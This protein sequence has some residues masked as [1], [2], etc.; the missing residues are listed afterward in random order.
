MI[1]IGNIVLW[2]RLTEHSFFAFDITSPADM[3]ALLY[4][5]DAPGCPLETYSKALNI[6]KGSELQ[7]KVKAISKDVEKF[8]QYASKPKE[9]GSSD[10]SDGESQK[11]SDIIG[12]IIFLGQPAPAIL[13]M[14]IDYL[15]FLSEQ[16]AAKVKRDAEHDRSILYTQLSPYLAEN[17]SI[18][19]FM[20]LPWDAEEEITDED[21]EIANFLFHHIDNDNQPS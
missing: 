9:D 4:V 7:K 11:V 10:S 20:P 3:A 12:Q 15:P 8:L 13:D 5:I 1:K 6:T 21:A 17:T 18:H 19:S 16:F 14:S 2:E